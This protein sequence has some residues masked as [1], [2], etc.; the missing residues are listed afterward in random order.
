MRG[1]H[2]NAEKNW[3]AA[4]A[5][6]EKA[7]AIDPS[8][9]AIWVQLGHARR[10]IGQDEQ[11]TKAYLRALQLAPFDKASAN[12]LNITRDLI[13]SQSKYRKKT[14]L[15]PVDY[16][17]SNYNYIR[18]FALNRSLR[19]LH[20][21]RYF[22]RALIWLGNRANA[23]K[24]WKDAIE[25]YERAL[26][27]NDDLT[28]IWIQLGHMRREVGQ[29][30]T[31]ETAYLRA[32]ELDPTN[33]DARFFLGV[34][35]DEL[36]RDI[37]A[38]PDAVQSVDLPIEEPATGNPALSFPFHPM[39]TAAIASIPRSAS[40]PDLPKIMLGDVELGV[41]DGATTVPV[42]G[43]SR[44]TETFN[45][46]SFCD[47][48]LTI[49]ERHIESSH[50]ETEAA[51][52]RA[53]AIPA[54]NDRLFETLPADLEL[55]D[56]WFV[57]E[58]LLRLR[59]T[60]TSRQASDRVIRIFQRSIADRHKLL[61]L[62]ETIVPMDQTA[63]LDCRTANPFMPLL[64]AIC[65]AEHRLL[66]LATLPFPS[67]CRGG[68][69]FGELLAVEP[70][71]P[72]V[73]ALETLSS[74]LAAAETGRQSQSPKI[75]RIVVDLSEATGREMIFSPALVAWLCHVLNIRFDSTGDPIAVNDA[76]ARYRA[77]ALEG[78][79]ANPDP[80]PSTLHLP[81]DAIPSLH[82]LLDRQI[83]VQTGEHCGS[84]V[85]ANLA[86]AQPILV[87]APPLSEA[88][89]PS[90]TRSLFPVISAS[91]PTPT[92]ANTPC[93]SK[94]PLAVRMRRIR[95]PI[96]AELL[97]P[98]GP[99]ISTRE[100]AARLGGG[101]LPPLTVICRF[102]GDERRLAGCMDA[103]LLQE[104]LGP[105]EAIV[106]AE[107]TDQTAAR[108]VLGR[109]FSSRGQIVDDRSSRRHPQWFKDAAQLAK[110]DFVL[111]L[112]DDLLFHDC[113]TLAVLMD[114]ASQ[115]K[116][117]SASC[118]LVGPTAATKVETYS[119][120]SAGRASDGLDAEEAAWSS[121]ETIDA[122]LHLPPVTWPIAAAPTH[123]IVMRRDI[124]QRIEPALSPAEGPPD[125]ISPQN[126]P[127]FWLEAGRLGLR[128]YVTTTVSASVTDRDAALARVSEAASLDWPLPQDG[129]KQ[130]VQVRRLVA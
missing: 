114:I 115:S 40:Q 86:D 45:R 9:T 1:D 39:P 24:D 48:S 64:I 73:E 78:R 81:S 17:K 60:P 108:R 25:F 92:D 28:A 47:A 51:M 122:L 38:P 59:W 20:G 33:N 21:G 99:E 23:A 116:T 14:E 119:M 15:K 85:L 62:S 101:S 117:A 54:Q 18:K 41:Y 118:I 5:H 103:I 125:A 16:K 102:S 128:H 121:S 43:W 87:I 53:S 22:V 97:R 50:D 34:T 37:W 52:A 71:R 7:L 79:S 69:H 109:L 8:L 98:L 67:L 30:A 124:W 74:L 6:Y 13:E 111:I 2:A 63:L 10:E 127:D 120:I 55:S 88:A 95:S 104:G 110:G 106:V 82:S 58:R 105:V 84:F 90:Q 75:E 26:A 11:A 94:A 126:L 35:R 80:S 112:D 68:V 107:K 96:E 83:V 70:Q 4:I 100:M 31:A 91:T 12:L 65:D 27:I 130:S 129:L 29:F 46:L 123:P 77:A 32:L 61:V 42:A 93:Q 56:V 49:G 113:R 72:Y 19:P 89:L 44:I 36:D 76:I 57:N 66:A 3:A